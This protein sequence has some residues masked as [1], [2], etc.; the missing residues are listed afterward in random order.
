[1]IEC[2]YDRVK[3][4]PGPQVADRQGENLRAA[5][6]PLLLQSRE[7]TLQPSASV[8]VVSG[9]DKHCRQ[10]GW[11]L[12][13]PSRGWQPMESS[14]VCSLESDPFPEEERERGKEGKGP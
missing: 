5:Y 14:I 9:G 8:G 1:M 12:D 6:P 7:I 13:S 3:R 10:A 4:G 2:Q 11:P